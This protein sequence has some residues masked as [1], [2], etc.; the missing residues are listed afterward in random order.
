MLLDRLSPALRLVS[1]V[2]I[3]LSGLSAAHA[4]PRRIPC[5]CCQ[6]PEVFHSDFFG[7]Y[8]TCWRP[9]PGTQPPCPVIG[10]VIA[11]TPLPAEPPAP[12]KPPEKLPSPRP[13]APPRK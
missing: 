2:L 8:R 10:V 7:Y 11:E 9:W 1:A 12:A 4:E 6:S 5:R 3:L 13:D